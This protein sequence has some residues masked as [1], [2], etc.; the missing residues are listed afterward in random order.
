MAP[1]TPACHVVEDDEDGPAIKKQRKVRPQPPQEDPR[2]GNNFQDPMEF[3]SSNMVELVDPANGN[4]YYGVHLGRPDGQD[5][6]GRIQPCNRWILGRNCKFD[7]S[8]KYAHVVP[9]P[10]SFNK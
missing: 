1:P 8:C 6:K 9:A 2:H 4:C 5:K 7:M 3:L 10:S